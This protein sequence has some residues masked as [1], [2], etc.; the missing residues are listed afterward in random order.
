MHT[1]NCDYQ[2]IVNMAVS[3]TPWCHLTARTRPSGHLASWWLEP[4]GWTTE[5]NYDAL[6]DE[7]RARESAWNTCPADSVCPSSI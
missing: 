2:L 4:A 5:Q 1:H 7:V 6:H 3:P